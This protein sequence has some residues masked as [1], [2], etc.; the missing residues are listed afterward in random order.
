MKNKRRIHTWLSSIRVHTCDIHLLALQK[1][2]QE[3]GACTSGGACGLSLLAFFWL[4]L[5]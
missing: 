2:W 5:S 1:Y 4:E 3:W